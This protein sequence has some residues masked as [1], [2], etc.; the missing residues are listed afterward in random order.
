MTPRH[1]LEIHNVALYWHF[2]L[3]T[4]AITVLVA[5]GFPLVSE[6]APG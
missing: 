3:L 5:A 2:A 1:D 4:V 6:G